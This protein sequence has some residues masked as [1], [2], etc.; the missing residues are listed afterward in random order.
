MK[1]SA[2]KQDYIWSFFAYILKFGVNLFVFPIVLRILDTAEY[3]L[4]V[5]FSSV[6]IIVNL[7]DFG[8]SSTIL[9][10]LAYVWGGSSKLQ[11]EGYDNSLDGAERDDKLFLI[12]VRTCKKIYF[13]IG[14][15]AFLGASTLGT[16]YILYIIRD[17]YKIEYVV[18]WLISVVGIT[19]NL[20]Y[21][22]WSVLLRGVGAV[23][24]TQ[25]ANVFGYLIQLIFSFAGMY[26][27]LGL[28]GLSTANCLCGISI[29]FLSHYYFK[30]YEDIETVLNTK[31]EITK[32]EIKDAFNKIWH[33]AKKAG[34]SSIA[35]VLMTQ[36]TTMLC[37][38]YF[39]VAATGEYGIC[40]QILSTV[41][42]VSQVFYQTTIPELTQLR[43]HNQ[44]EKCRKK[45]SESMTVAWIIFFA[46]VFVCLIFGDVMLKLIESQ[47]RLNITMFIVMAYYSFGEM[48]YSMHATFISLENRLPFVSSV[49][50]TSVVNVAL[51]LLCIFLPFKVWGLLLVRC[52]TETA[53]IFW[54]WPAEAQKQLALNPIKMVKIGVKELTTFVLGE[55]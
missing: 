27:G 48:N 33:N 30:N 18:A 44:I 49:V 29:R 53:Y 36:S 35:T 19:M 24:Q 34:I 39:G 2:T 37:S 28:I 32:Q 31:Y 55:K 54:K 50:I 45:F 4:W 40:Y 6:T 11:A 22:Y 14:V 43:Q 13:T 10:N 17:M 16:L 8:F 1:I 25:K 51:S 46:G 9:R 15:L 20:Y 23:K 38:A 3:G 41:T 21:G 42:A 7:F 12:T 26:M 5:T 47:T 52:I